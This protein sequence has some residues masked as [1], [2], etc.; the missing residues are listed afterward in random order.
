MCVIISPNT[1]TY[2]SN[3]FVLN[4]L[5]IRKQNNFELFYLLGENSIVVNITIACRYY[6]YRLYI[7]ICSLTCVRVLFQC[8]SCII[9]I[10]S[11]EF[12]SLASL[13]NRCIG[14]C[15]HMYK[16]QFI[17]IHWTHS[18]KSMISLMWEK[19]IYV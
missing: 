18:H 7:M 16:C 19:N 10:N 17:Y 14:V 2:K 6:I 12:Q 8:L 11:A 5:H 3:G 13:F 4:A 9:Y 1:H 15:I